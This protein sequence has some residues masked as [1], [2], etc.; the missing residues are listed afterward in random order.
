V[1]NGASMT[2]KSWKA[3]AAVL[4]VGAVVTCLVWPK[5]I[6]LVRYTTPPIAVG[7][8]SVRV[9]GLIPDGWRTQFGPPGSSMSSPGLALAPDPPLTWVPWRIREGLVDVN[10][11]SSCLIIQ[12]QEDTSADRMTKVG[13]DQPPVASRLIS[14]MPCVVYYRN[15]DASAFSVTY[16]K[17]CDSFRV[18]P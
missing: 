4:L 12:F 5:P 10:R 9:T 18:V 3:L 14:E 11:P 17:V 16:R 1:A 7:T 8:R 13:E 15:L 6:R 2:G